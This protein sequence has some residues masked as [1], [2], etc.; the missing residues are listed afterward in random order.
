MPDLSDPRIRR[1]VTLLVVGA[2]FGGAVVA[3]IALAVD[4]GEGGDEA[5]N[6]AAGDSTAVSEQ[7]APTIDPTDTEFGQLTEEA[8]AAGVMVQWKAD[9]L[10]GDATGTVEFVTAHREGTTVLVHEDARVIDDGKT[11]RLCTPG[12]TKVDAAK[13]RDA[14]PEL[15]RPYWEV[16]RLVEETTSRP[17]YRVTGETQLDSGIFERCGTFDP[18]SFGVVVPDNV[19]SVSQC[20]D[21]SRTVPIRIGLDGDQRSVGG[22]SLTALADATEDL[23]ET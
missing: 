14:L 8:A 17:E 15:V 20:V 23:F 9:I 3:G 6:G 7:E 1:D 2:L 11:I 21:A 19:I 5:K 13:A 12:C 22:A 10:E 18:E 16:I 4:G